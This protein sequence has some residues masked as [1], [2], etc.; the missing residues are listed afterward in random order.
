MLD[1]AYYYRTLIEYLWLSTLGR[2]A[3]IIT[4]PPYNKTGGLL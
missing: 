1:T 2:L 3:L 4:P